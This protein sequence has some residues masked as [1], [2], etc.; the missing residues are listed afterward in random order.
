M[1]A[2]LYEIVRYTSETKAVFYKERIILHGSATPEISRLSIAERTG[3]STQDYFGDTSLYLKRQFTLLL[4]VRWPRR[5][6]QPSIKP[7]I[8]ESGRLWTGIN[9]DRDHISA[10]HAGFYGACV[11]LLERKRC[12]FPLRNWP[13]KSPR[14]ISKKWKATLRASW[15]KVQGI[16]SLDL[17]IMDSWLDTPPPIGHRLRPKSQSWRA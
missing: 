7:E 12:L 13:K 15:S 8:N 2:E 3:L 1:R 17:I 4:W 5:R 11:L 10:A 6:G 16:G 14:P 9:V